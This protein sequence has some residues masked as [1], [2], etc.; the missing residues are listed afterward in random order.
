MYIYHITLLKLIKDTFDQ[1]ACTTRNGDQGYVTFFDVDVEPT[2]FSLS[3]KMGFNL[4]CDN[5]YSNYR[6]CSGAF[7]HYFPSE[8]WHMNG[9]DEAISSIKLATLPNALIWSDTVTEP[10]EPC[11]PVPTV[12]DSEDLKELQRKI[13]LMGR[14]S[15]DMSNIDDV[16]EE[17]MRYM[18]D[19][20][21]A[22]VAGLDMLKSLVVN[23]KDPS[24][25]CTL[26]SAIS[27]IDFMLPD[28]WLREIALFALRYP[29]SAHR[30]IGMRLVR[31]LDYEE[32]QGGMSDIVSELTRLV[33]EGGTITVR[34]DAKD[35]LNEIAKAMKS[36]H[37]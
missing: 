2:E 16:F 27:S 26:L 18:M 29:H 5:E 33:N 30:A 7:E 34:E 11:T 23:E 32:L 3:Q 15:T 31:S 10:S 35:T 36:T 14:C 9:L 24:V 8:V 22:D 20:V 28:E 13:L 25:Q 12:R 4:Y 6:L 19:L 37:G 17:L 1:E 21:R